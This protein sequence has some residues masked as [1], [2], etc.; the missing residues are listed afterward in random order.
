[1]LIYYCPTTT[2][3]V[4]TSIETSEADARRLSVFKLSL[5]CPYCQMGHSILGKD[6]QVVADDM[7]PA[8]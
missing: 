3:I 2:R 8:A 1:M 5:W 4:R 7:R 6:T